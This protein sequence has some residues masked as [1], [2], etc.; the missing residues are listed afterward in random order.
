MGNFAYVKYV[1]ALITKSHVHCYL[2]PHMSYT[3][4][5]YAVVRELHP[6]T[7]TTQSI[8]CSSTCERVHTRSPICLAVRV[9]VV[10][11]GAIW[12][13]GPANTQ[14]RSPI[15]SIIT[16]LCSHMFLA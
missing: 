1:T 2:L 3:F 8:V 12:L 6:L 14:A 9:T 4:I 15:H 11:P 10:H 13:K 5:A 16:L 7:P